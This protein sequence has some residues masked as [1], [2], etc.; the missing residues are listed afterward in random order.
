MKCQST[1]YIYIFKGVSDV[2][3]EACENMK[4]INPTKIQIETIP[5]A[6]QGII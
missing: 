2:I 6:L 4:W 1:Q 5:V 3:C